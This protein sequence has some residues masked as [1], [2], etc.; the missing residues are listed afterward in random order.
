MSAE[1]SIL[2]D[3]S[4]VRPEICDFK[5]YVPGLSI[6]EI[7]AKYRLNTV[8]KM[9]SNENPLGTP[10]L[11]QDA[12]KKYANA[13]F[14]YPQSGNKRLVK[15]LAEHHGISPSKIVIGN[16]SDEIIDILI[17]IRATANVNNIV[18]FKPCFSMY[19][20]Q[21]KLC[22]VLV[23]RHPLNEDFSFA[24]QE[25]FELVDDKTALVFITTPDNPSGYMPK[26]A[27]V[28]KFAKTLPAS[29]MLV[30]DEAY[31]DFSH[32]ES[33]FS[34][35]YL[36]EIPANIIIIRTFSK[37]FGLAGLRLGYGVL[38]EKLADYYWRV[39][40]PFSVNILAEEAGL[41]AL[42]D[43][44]F[45][46]ETLRVV[47]EG[48]E[49]LQTALSKMGCFVYASQA[50]FCMFEPRSNNITA[51]DIFEKLLHKGI[52]I[53]PLASYG[54]P[55]LLR[56]SIGNEKENKYFIAEISKILA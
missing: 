43:K 24:W 32:D 37:S 35:L 15:A 4:I 16:G 27:E 25:L 10:P 9:A 2:D 23:R 21:A 51:L 53:R 5:A 30:V 54:L 28:I 44:V 7:K 42:E 48:R 52:I 8:F 56:V 13:I 22:G 19:E 12:V 50:N 11:A 55:H 34:I 29:C 14:R 47:A 49:Y 33:D 41:A 36:S 18:C 1:A 26:R 3:K 46:L 31:M 6:D 40:L 45:R 39:R 38:P 20:L 17:R